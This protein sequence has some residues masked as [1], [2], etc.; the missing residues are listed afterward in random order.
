M[1]EFKIYRGFLCHDNEKRYKNWNG[2]DLS[3]LN[4]HEEF[5]EFWQK[6]SKV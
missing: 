3:F 2:I 4:W 6:Y 5:D 1:Y